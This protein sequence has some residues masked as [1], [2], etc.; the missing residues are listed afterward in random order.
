[1]APQADRARACRG[2]MHFGKRRGDGWTR[3]TLEGAEAVG[4]RGPRKCQ[5]RR[6]N[7][8][9]AALLIRD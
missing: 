4:G 3:Y 2:A 8:H 5:Q 9:G 1:M 6:F 7:M